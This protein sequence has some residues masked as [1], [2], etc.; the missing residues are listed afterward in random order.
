MSTKAASVVF[1]VIDSINQ[2]LLIYSLVLCRGHHRMQ[3]AKVD[4]INAEHMS[5]D[6]RRHHLAGV[7]VRYDRAYVE[8]KEERKH[9]TVVYRE[10]PEIA[11]ELDGTRVLQVFIPQQVSDPVVA[12]QTI[13]DIRIIKVR[14]LKL[15]ISLPHA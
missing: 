12:K 13:V 9:E 3:G 7:K 10:D 4:S 15:I 11:P 1:I 14:L 8:V 6:A 2:Y 5:H